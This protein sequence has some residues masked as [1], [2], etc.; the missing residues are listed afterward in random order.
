MT[1]DSVTCPECQ[2]RFRCQHHQLEA[3]DGFLRCGVCQHVFNATQQLSEDRQRALNLDTPPSFANDEIEPPPTA[4][5]GQNTGPALALNRFIPIDD[6]PV[7]TE[8]SPL[9]DNHGGDSDNQDLLNGLSTLNH[10]FEYHQRRPHGRRWPW[11]IVNLC[12]IVVLAAQIAYW[13]RDW[14]LNHPQLD[15]TVKS[16]I[17]DFCQQVSVHCE[18]APAP[19]TGQTSVVSRNLLV[20]QHPEVDHAL[21][22]DAILLN[23]AEHKTP[24]PALHLS[25]SDIHGTEVASRIFSPREYLAG[26]LNALSSLA[27]QQPVHIALEIVNPGAEAVNYQLKLLAAQ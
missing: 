19:T 27:S 25:F 17:L 26:E 13:Q 16:R 24:F 22:V 5:P 2:T 14:I 11:V 7:T 9:R 18:N 23:P 8:T 20:R 1:V 15:G 10:G 21:I 3:A 12:A 6:S 4:T